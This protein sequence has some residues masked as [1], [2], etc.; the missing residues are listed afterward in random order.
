MAGQSPQHRSV[1]K[2]WHAQCRATVMD[3]TCHLYARALV[4][5]DSQS[6][7]DPKGQRLHHKEVT[8]RHLKKA[9]INTKN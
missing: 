1:K 4:P 8:R 9:N 6:K 2:S 7:R 5:K 3:R